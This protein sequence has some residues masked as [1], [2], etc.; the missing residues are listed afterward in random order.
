MHA[1]T[2]YRGGILLANNIKEVMH[3]ES[4]FEDEMAPSIED[5][6]RFVTD[7]SGCWKEA[8]CESL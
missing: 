2:S 7:H 1:N 8:E 3:V 4:V 5:S 6:G